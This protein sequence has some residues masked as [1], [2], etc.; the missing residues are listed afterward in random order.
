MNR[1]VHHFGDLLFVTSKHISTCFLRNCTLTCRQLTIRNISFLIAFIW[2]AIA[3]IHTSTHRYGD[4]YF[5]NYE[6]SCIYKRGQPTNRHIGNVTSRVRVPGP[7]AVV[8]RVHHH[9]LLGMTEYVS[10]LQDERSRMKA[11]LVVLHDLRGGK[12][13]ECKHKDGARVRLTSSC[14]TTDM[15]AT[16]C[17]LTRFSCA[18]LF[19]L[20][21]IQQRVRHAQ[22]FYLSPEQNETVRTVSLHRVKG[23]W[24]NTPCYREC[25]TL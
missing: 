15:C 20:D 1:V 6:S 18:R 23:E 7:H 12:P 22:V 5:D 25:S 21:H 13:N 4:H 16:P 17:A 14:A 19:V 11:D 3:D 24:S 8:H 10:E 2:Q 9:D